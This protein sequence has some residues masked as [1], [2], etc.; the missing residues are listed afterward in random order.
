MTASVS[1]SVFRAI[2]GA[3][4]A[5]RA[6][7]DDAI[8]GVPAAFV[9]QPASTEEAASTL[10]S[11]SSNDVPVVVRGG[12]SKLAWGAPPE[13][14][15]VV[16]S[17][18]RMSSVIEHAAGD[19][20]A[21]AQPGVR[22]ADLQATLAATG[23]MLALDPPEEGATLGG[24]V[25]SAASGPRR[26]RYGTPRDLVIGLTVVLSDGTIA[27]AGG[28]VVKNVAGYDLGK[29]FAGSF[30]TLGLIA[31]LT[32]RLHP[33]PEARRAVEVSVGTP[34]AALAAVRLATS[35]T[36]VPSAVEL[37]WEA[38]A[39]EGRVRAL[40]EGVE[41]G[42]EA[43]ASRIRSLL[44][45]PSTRGIGS[46]RVNDAWAAASEPSSAATVKLTHPPAELSRAIGAAWAA[47]D[48]HHLGARLS[49]HAATG[50]TFV[51][52]GGGAE[53]SSL[54]AMVG[55]LRSFATELGGAAVVLAAPPEVKRAVDVWGRGGDAL[56]LM[57]RVKERFDPTG[58]M[59]PGRF[60][61]GI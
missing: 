52:I 47:G 32:L 28:R 46:P 30:G 56:E 57:R 3:D 2:V 20:V 13:R 16:L 41:P 37:S 40:Y 42:V 6:G 60:V 36:L 59:S 38:G 11:C 48:R 7:P 18:T 25:A 14:V 19:L 31:E 8:D 33:L 44:S 51:R 50:V 1:L 61:G 10:R 55:D 9:V 26:L 34:E 39:D 53:P 49:G 15:G 29:L 45:H 58:T 12:G 43:Q 17:T 21:I 35:A 4:D 22:L 27:R 5:R 54:A 24:I 23:Q